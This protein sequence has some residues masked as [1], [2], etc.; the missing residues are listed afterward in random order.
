MNRPR[1]RCDPDPASPPAGRGGDGHRAARTGAAP[2]LLLAAACY[3]SWLLAPVLNPGL[4]PVQSYLSELAARDQPY[5]LVF[6]AGDVTT[7][8][9]ATVAGLLLARVA[10][11]VPRPAWWGL[12]VFGVATAVDGG[13]TSMDCAPSIDARCARLEELGELSWRHQAHTV[14]SSVAV[15]GALLSLVAVLAVLRGP[16]RRRAGLAVAVVLAVGTVGTLVATLHPE[17]GLGLWQRVQLTGLSGWLL[18]TAAVARWGPGP[19]RP[20]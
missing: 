7:G 12:L 3:A 15:A 14:T 17:W 10:R 1:P 2:A 16:A 20:R 4:R 19:G 8:L 11:E 13:Y 18:L 5:H 6:Q 9:C